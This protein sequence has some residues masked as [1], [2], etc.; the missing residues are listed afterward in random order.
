MALKKVCADIDDSFAGCHRHLLKDL[1]AIFSEADSRG[2]QSLGYC[3]STIA[4]HVPAAERRTIQE[5]FLTS[6]YIGIRKRGYKSISADTDMAQDLVQKAWDRF[7]DPECAWV[8]V[9]AFPI[10]FLVLHRAELATAFS[11]GWQFA[12]LYLRIAESEPNLLDE[13]RNIDEISYCYV[14]AKLDRKLP[15]KEAVKIVDKNL[16]DERF[17]LL[18]W[19]LGRLRMWEALQ[20]VES[21]LPA[22]QEKRLADMRA[23]YGI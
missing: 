19:S 22:M 15:L 13:L 8:I 9:K 21:Q 3:L 2:R 6:K 20:H 18:V 12:R 11:E 7:A 1:L 23:K 4:D 5:F 14:L 10:E 16:G 17:G